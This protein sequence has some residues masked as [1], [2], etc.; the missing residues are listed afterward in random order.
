M[1]KVHLIEG[2]GFSG[3]I[4]LIDCDQPVMIDAGWDSEL[5]PITQKVEDI[6]K[7]RKLEKIIL[8]HRHI[9][10]VGGAL[11]IQKKWGGALFAQK[12]E[13]EAL[14]SGDR[15][16]TGAQMFGSSIQPMEVEDLANDDVIELDP[17][18]SL[19]VMETPGHTSGS[20]CLISSTDSI[21]SGDTV[22]TSGGVGRWDLPTGNYKQLL[23]SIEKLAKMDLKTIFPGHG[24]LE[25]DGNYHI[26]LGLNYLKEF[27]SYV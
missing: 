9:D 1:M 2:G 20:I 11:A 12:D 7:D 3:N 10:H 4:Y 18:H 5:G 26:N 24:F 15:I 13:A 6:L 14:R 17:D 23:G 21:F 22:F 27:G 8:T 16:S 19:R 25:K